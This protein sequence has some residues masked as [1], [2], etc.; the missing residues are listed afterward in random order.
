MCAFGLRRGTGY[1][2]SA[3][4][5]IIENCPVKIDTCLSYCH[6]SMN[7]STLLDFLPYLQE[8]GIGLINASVG[9][10]A[11][12]FIVLEHVVALLMS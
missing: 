3:Q 4:K 11:G 7:D 6:Y 12:L 9:T 2:L 1:P 10:I 8:K 5:Y